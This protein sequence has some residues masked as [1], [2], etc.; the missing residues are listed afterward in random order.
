MN[1]FNPEQFEAATI[2]VAQDRQKWLNENSEKYPDYCAAVK[3]LEELQEIC[4]RGAI[5][6]FASLPFQNGPGYAFFRH[7]DKHTGIYDE[8][9]IEQEYIASHNQ[10]PHTIYNVSRCYKVAHITVTDAFSDRCF[11]IPSP[12]KKSLES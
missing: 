9:F 4:D 2:T 5:P 10:L 7:L 3:K 1:K 6:F 11:T 8:G 12:L